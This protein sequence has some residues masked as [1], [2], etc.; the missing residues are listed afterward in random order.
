MFGSFARPNM[1]RSSNPLTSFPATSNHDLLGTL[2]IPVFLFATC[3]YTYHTG[4]SRTAVWY[5]ETLW[6][7]LNAN[8]RGNRRSAY[9]M[10]CYG[11]NLATYGDLTRET[12]FRQT[13]VLRSTSQAASKRNL[14]S[15]CSVVRQQIVGCTDSETPRMVR[16]LSTVR[17]C[18]G[19][20]KF[21][22]SEHQ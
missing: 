14:K 22:T 9:Y 6:Q 17:G 7:L 11:G 20:A 1:G 16:V 13:C 3:L 15:A 2:R 8:C 21:R 18:R 19:T 12:K 5:S 4:G 10:V